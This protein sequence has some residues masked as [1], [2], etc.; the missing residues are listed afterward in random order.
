MPHLGEAETVPTPR[1]GVGRPRVRPYDG[2]SPA[3]TTLHAAP[4]RG[5]VPRLEAAVR[6]P[7]NLE[8]PTRTGARFRCGAEAESSGVSPA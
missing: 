2:A 3:D 6:I 8:I 5:G 4:Q 1:G 7:R